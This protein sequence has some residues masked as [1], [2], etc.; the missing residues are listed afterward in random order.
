MTASE[1]AEPRRPTWQWLPVRPGDSA[2][3]PTS[4][5]APVSARFTPAASS[6]AAVS[7]PSTRLPVLLRPDGGRNLPKTS[8][9][10][11]KRRS[12]VGQP[13]GRLLAIERPQSVA[14]HVS[15]ARLPRTSS[16]PQQVRATP[17][18][19]PLV[20]GS[21]DAGPRGRARG[22]DISGPGTARRRRSTASRRPEADPWRHAA[23]GPA[24]H[25]SRHGEGN[26][27]KQTWSC[28][29]ISNENRRATVSAGSLQR[30][31]GPRA[32]RRGGSSAGARLDWLA[33]LV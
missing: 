14:M 13:V 12:E 3:T 5:S 29:R 22:V 15:R 6:R 17:A 7:A 26:G 16:S 8:P 2:L 18:H 23:G 32:V 19:C 4:R 10:A 11:D 33:L 25:S 1:R 28:P 20:L 21:P 27:A 30:H 24:R 9:L 31:C